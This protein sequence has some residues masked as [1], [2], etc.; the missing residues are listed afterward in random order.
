VSADLRRRILIG[1]AL[2]AL[3]LAIA[4]FFSFLGHRD[5]GIERHSAPNGSTDG[6]YHTCGYITEDGVTDHLAAYKAR[7]NRGGQRT[8]RG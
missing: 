5:Q 4:L 7:C 2:I 3:A 8:Y 6:R 1:A